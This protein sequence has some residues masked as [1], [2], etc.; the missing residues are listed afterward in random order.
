LLPVEGESRFL[1][2]ACLWQAIRSSERQRKGI[3]VEKLY[4]VYILARRSRMLY[5]GVTNNLLRRISQHRDG[6][7]EGFAS[8][9]RIH[10]L[11]H[12]ETFRDIRAAIAREKEIKGWR[13][14][15]K[16]ALVEL[17]NPTWEDLAEHLFP[18]YKREEKADPS[19]RSG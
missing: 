13:R 4:Y 14:S 19:L 8:R 9:Y 18:R 16:V 17:K 1:G 15:K 12:S 5:T 7:V 2:T 10:R 6:L 3:A 11:V